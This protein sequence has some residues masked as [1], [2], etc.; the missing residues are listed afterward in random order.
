MDLAAAVAEVALDLAQ[1]RRRRIACEGVAERRIEAFDRLHE[2]EA[3]DLVEILRRL[4]TARVA[5]GEA[6]CERH[7]PDDQLLT[8][9]RALVPVVALEQKLFVGQ[10]LVGA[11]QF[12][13]HAHPGCSMKVRGAGH[14]VHASRNQSQL[15]GGGTA[16][17]DRF[18]LHCGHPLRTPLLPEHR[19]DRHHG[20]H[21]EHRRKNIDL[22][23]D[24]SERD[25]VDVK[26]ERHG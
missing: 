8:H 2:P 4:G 15:D 16:E 3:R 10:M 14:P 19:D 20:D 11:W 26:R 5:V 23:R 9:Q 7:E 25:A 21:E 17:L 24:T 6:A 22:H 13:P 12:H 18:R 1:D